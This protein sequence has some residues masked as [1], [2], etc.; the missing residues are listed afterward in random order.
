MIIVSFPK[1]SAIV[2]LFALHNL[3]GIDSKKLIDGFEKLGVTFKM[4]TSYKFVDLLLI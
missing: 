1:G 2:G 4:L 3:H